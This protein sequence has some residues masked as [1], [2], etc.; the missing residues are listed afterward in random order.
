MEGEQH[1]FICGV[2]LHFSNCK[3]IQIDERKVFKSYIKAG[4][5]LENVTHARDS[6]A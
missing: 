3:Q 2:S 6:F 4:S 1:Y 5:R